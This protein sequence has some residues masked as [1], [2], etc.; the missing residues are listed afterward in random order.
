M[1]KRIAINNN[2]NFRDLSAVTQ[3]APSKIF[4]VVT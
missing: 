1:Q 3:P 2:S 4:Q